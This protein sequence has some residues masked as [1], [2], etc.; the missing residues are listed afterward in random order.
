MN[1]L[2][3]LAASLVDGIQTD[4]VAANNFLYQLLDV[5]PRYI[6]KMS[7]DG[8]IETDKTVLPVSGSAAIPL[9]QNYVN[10]A[11]L[12]V[13]MTADQNAK[14]VAPG[15]GTFLIKAG[16][17]SD[18]PGFV[19]FVGP[20]TS[21]TVTSN[22]AVPVNLEWMLFQLPALGLNASWLYGSQSTGVLGP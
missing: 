12:Y 3:Q 9:P 2:R 20:V 11:N 1:I 22:A 16:S 8:L 10:S 13:L 15:I 4:M 14:V 21:L 5:N 7:S 17:S 6:L 18:Q 19:A